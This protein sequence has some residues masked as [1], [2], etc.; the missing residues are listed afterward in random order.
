MNLTEV[1]NDPEE[2]EKFIVKRSTGGKF[3]AG[4]WQDVST[5][6]N[7]YGRITIAEASDTE[8]LP[9]GDRIHNSIVIN[10]ELPLYVTRVAN[11]GTKT[12]GLADQIIY[13]GDTYR[14]LKVNDYSMKGYYWAI[15]ARMVGA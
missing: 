2:C 5:L 7:Y 10:C 8:A 13:K 4:V 14:I 1:V 6:L 3:V 12:A 15:A 9:E 11:E